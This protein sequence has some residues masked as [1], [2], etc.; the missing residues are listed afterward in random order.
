MTATPPD[1]PSADPVIIPVSIT[2]PDPVR[3][4]T[5]GMSRLRR[6]GVLPAN[7]W[8]RPPSVNHE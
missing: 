4:R 1:I 8:A 2:I 5:S 6:P 7:G 3:E